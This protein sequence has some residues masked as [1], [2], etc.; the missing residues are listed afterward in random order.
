LEE[1]VAPVRLHAGTLQLASRRVNRLT[2]AYGPAI[3]LISLL[4]HGQGV[5][6]AATGT[7]QPLAGF[8]F[9]MN[10]FFQSLMS[11]FL[12]ES[13]PDHSVRDEHQLRGMIQY[14]SG[15]NPQNR[16]PPAPR[17][18]FVVSRGAKQVAVLDAK[19][20]D[21]WQKPLPRE[22][23][24][25]LALYAAGNERRVAAIL[26]P[27]TDS[28]AHEAR[29]NITDPV[30]GRPIGQVCLRPV[31]LQQL[32]DLVLSRSTAAREMKRRS[33]GQWLALGAGEML[34]I[35]DSAT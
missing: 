13:L 7:T 20:R 11:R 25:Q 15:F 21:L 32:E 23:L 12:R 18:D 1:Q 30:F 35:T 26:Y 3:T 16:R 10:R 5:V 2:A 17:P 19:Y 33:Y 28:A 8:L 24:Y 31:V 29:L 34:S 4:W 27:T 22:M 6:L 14:A 9:D